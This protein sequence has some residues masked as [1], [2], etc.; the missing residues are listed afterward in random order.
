[1][2]QGQGLLLVGRVPRVQVPSHDS[3]TSP[4][5]LSTIDLSALFTATE[6]RS[7]LL[8][9]R[10]QI[11]I[12]GCISVSSRKKSRSGELTSEIFALILPL[13]R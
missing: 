2:A 1:M 10:K 6:S 4:E 3:G 5:S 13:L 8:E 11:A 12:F 7:W 9:D